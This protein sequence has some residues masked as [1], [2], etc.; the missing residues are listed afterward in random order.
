MAVRRNINMAA[1]T[2]PFRIFTPQHPVMDR[3]TITPFLA[4]LFATVIAPLM[5]YI[6]DDVTGITQTLNRFLW[7]ALAAI[8]VVV[9]LQNHLRL[10][11]VHWSPHVLLL[12][13][14]LSLAGASVLWA[15][16]PELSLIRFARQ[17][18]IVVAIVFPAFLAYQRPDLL[19]G[20][21]LCFALGTLLNTVV[22]FQNT[23]EQVMFYNGYPGYFYGKNYLGQFTA[24]ALILAFHEVFHPG[25]RR[26]FG[27]ATALVAAL[28]LYWSNSKTAFG[29]A[30][31]VPT[32]SGFFLLMARWWRISPAL[33]FLAIPVGY[34]VLATVTGITFN[35]LSY[36]VYGDPTF[37]GRTTI[38]AFADYEIARKPLLG[39][40]YQS[41][42][43]VGSNAPSV[44]DAPGW[45][46]M[47][48]NAHNGYRDILLETGYVGLTIALCFIFATIHAIGRLVQRDFTRAWALLSLAL[49]AITVNFLESLWFRGY[50]FLW[51]VFLIVV[52]ETVRTPRRAAATPQVPVLPERYR[53][54]AFRN[55][56]S[57]TR[58]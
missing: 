58:H 29:L 44:V 47:M 32:L 12:F 6:T 30:L 33:I 4:C 26:A 36:I 7:P 49:F 15:F 46:K 5:M 54:S 38:W 31:L 10:R 1:P 53:L 2:R 9:G 57:A 56:S 25:L 37:T 20:A 27:L 55:K 39:W 22:I 18:L 28:L 8:A 21:F 3:S 19:R 35:R 24:I 16:N 48:P 45:V 13:A 42:W 11:R 17:A 52:A 34:I 43:L 14:Y 23:T 41:F 40:G 51:V 50:E